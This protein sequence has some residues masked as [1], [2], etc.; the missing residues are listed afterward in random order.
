[1]KH[2]LLGVDPGKVTGL[3]TA[4]ICDGEVFIADAGNTPAW[5]SRKFIGP[6]E[7]SA[8]HMPYWLDDFQA[9]YTGFDIATAVERFTINARTARASQ[10]TDALE[11][12]GMVRATQAIAT[13]QQPMRRYAKSN[14]A[15]LA[16]NAVLQDI[17]WYPQGKRHATDA[18]RQTFRLLMEID[19]PLWSRVASR[20]RLNADAARTE[21]T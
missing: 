13:H 17:G 10:E 16:S 14:L 3:F 7:V 18:A 12:T 8:D 1:M 11:V 6:V 15:K 5:L 19:Y 21:E 4:V 2:V 20:A 9:H